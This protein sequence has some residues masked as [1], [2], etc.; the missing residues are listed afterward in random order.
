MQF[1]K[2]S[3]T[4]TYMFAI[5][6]IQGKQYKVSPKD[7]IVVD[8]MEGEIG[9]TV[10]CTDVLLVS[11]DKKTSIGTPLVSKKSVKAKILSHGKGEK[12]DVFRFRAKSRHRRHVGFRASQTTLEILSI[13]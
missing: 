5:V 4:I 10:A 1:I 11:D 13:E 6:R 2:F 9:A 12:L 8:R 3:S 7:T